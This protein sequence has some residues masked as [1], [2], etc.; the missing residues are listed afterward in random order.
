M[1]GHLELKPT[2]LKV[3]IFRYEITKSRKKKQSCRVHIFQIKKKYNNDLKILNW[4]YVEI[5]RKILHSFAFF[6]RRAFSV[7]ALLLWTLHLVFLF[8]VRVLLTWPKTWSWLQR[9][10][11]W[12]QVEVGWSSPPLT[13]LRNW[14]R[15]WL[16][17]FLVFCRLMW[18]ERENG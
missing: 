10:R 2:N 13:A 7:I 6:Y 3:H 16:L 15:S 9:R 17:L 11:W 18:F 14:T 1:F 12:P 8:R 4:V 5:R